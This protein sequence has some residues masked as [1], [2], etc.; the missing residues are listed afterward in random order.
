MKIKFNDETSHNFYTDLKPC[1]R[2]LDGVMLR[3]P[4]PKIF[5]NK[6]KTSLRETSSALESHTHFGIRHR[7]THQE[8][9]S[10]KIFVWHH[11]Y[12][13][14]SRVVFPELVD[15]YHKFYDRANPGKLWLWIERKPFKCSLGK[16]VWSWDC[17]G[18]P[19]FNRPMST[20]LQDSF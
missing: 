4:S 8:T 2:F 11:C 10:P 12:D 18:N 6:R 16:P 1:Y 5:R 14:G 7:I 15:L 19:M 17:D 20:K 3:K 13:C 9:T